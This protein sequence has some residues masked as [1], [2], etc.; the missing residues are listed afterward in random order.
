MNRSV[1]NKNCACMSGWCMDVEFVSQKKKE[2]KKE[3]QRKKNK[4]QVEF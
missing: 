4:Q 1:G 3:R 2:R